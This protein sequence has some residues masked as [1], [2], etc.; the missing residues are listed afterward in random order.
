MKGCKPSQEDGFFGRTAYIIS[1]GRIN[2][3]LSY[4]CLFLS[5][6]CYLKHQAKPNLPT[7]SHVREGVGSLI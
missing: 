4:V 3:L 1:E 7:A 5:L 2:T 6:I